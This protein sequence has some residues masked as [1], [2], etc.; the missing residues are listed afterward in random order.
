MQ[1]LACD[2]CSY[3]A[4]PACLDIRSD[5]C[6]MF[7]A[8]SMCDTSVSESISWLQSQFQMCCYASMLH[9][10]CLRPACPVDFDE[11]EIPAVF[12][13]CDVCV[14]VFGART[15][16]MVEPVNTNS[17]LIY[18]KSLNALSH[19]ICVTAG[20]L[21]YVKAYVCRRSRVYCLN[22]VQMRVCE[23]PKI[24]SC[25]VSLWVLM[26]VPMY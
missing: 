18:W 2:W 8:P 13:L 6:F 10:E 12:R 16:G 3:I 14:C 1:L 4:L 11:Y 15:V 26:G 21:L 5:L 24:Q 22:T 7:H 19:A 25:L 17:M 20:V 23:S 9:W